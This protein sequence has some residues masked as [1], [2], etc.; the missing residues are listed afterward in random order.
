M[1]D[2]MRHPLPRSTHTIWSRLDQ[3]DR[4][5]RV[6]LILVLSLLGAILVT[7][8]SG[9]RAGVAV[10]NIAPPSIDL[11][12]ASSRLLTT[13]RT[14]LEFTFSEPMQPATVES[15][16]TI[17]PELKGSFTWIGAVLRF[18][19]TVA[20][21]PNT[22]YAIRIDAGALSVTGRRLLTSVE[23]TLEAAP[24]RVVYLAPALEGGEPVAPNLY[25]VSPT[26]PMQSTALTNEPNG[27]ENY[28][29]NPDGTLIA[30][31]TQ[32]GVG[33]ADLML[34]DLRDG[35]RRRLTQCVA[36]LCQRPSWNPDGLRMAYERTET[37]T[38]L[39]DLE[40]SS[41]RTWILTLRD[42]RTFPLFK[43]SALLGAHPKWSPDGTR[44]ALYDRN[45]GAIGIVT[46]ATGERRDIPTQEGVTGNY[47]W[48]PDSTQLLYPQLIALAGNFTNEFWLADLPKRT[49][50]SLSGPESAPVNDRSAAWNAATGQ[51][52][53]A[54]IAL[55]Q[56]QAQTAQLMEITS[57]TQAASS[58]LVDMDYYHSALAWAP[59]GD[60]LTMM[61]VRPADAA[62]IP[63][64]WVY[65]RTTKRLWQVADNGFLPQWIP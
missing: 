50:T 27:V 49:L 33:T 9:D 45:L 36:A 28:A 29:V 21:K 63:G 34:L 1:A 16:F 22:L 35:T 55:D 43:E 3:F 52:T 8:L 5:D 64:I 7:I 60:W 40:R 31:A 11:A 59:A 51:I 18:T 32:T 30:Y 42:L 38:T 17:Q 61:R 19:P 15:R 41:P 23:T 2:S 44:I 65:D 37:A 39:S 47:A 54:R 62:P 58:M 48:S 26:T 53:I 57:P 14:A 46:V 25:V 20:W 10:M 13:T 24:P 12:A 56:P 4:L 6:T